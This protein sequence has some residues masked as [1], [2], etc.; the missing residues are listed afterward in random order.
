MDA[1]VCKNHHFACA[2]DPWM[3]ED[4]LYVCVQMKNYSIKT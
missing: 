1:V 3:F 4:N 2:E